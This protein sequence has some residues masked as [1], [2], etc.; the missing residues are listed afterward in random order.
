MAALQGE[1]LINNPGATTGTTPTNIGTEAQDV[2]KAQGVAYEGIAKGAENTATPA[3]ADYNATKVAGDVG[4][5][6]TPKAATSYYDEAQSTVAGRLNS[7]LSSDSAYIKQAEQ[8]AKEEASR[9]GL[10]NSSMAIGAGREAAISQALPIASQDASEFNKFG[11]QQQQTENQQATIQTE[12]IVS[13]EMTKQKAAISQTAQ[14]I[15]NAFNSRLTG[16]NEESKAWLQDLSQSHQTALQELE[17]TQN[18]ALQQFDTT[19]KKA[20]SIRTQA[21]QVMQN[22]QISVE[23]LMTDPDFL[24][25]GTVAVNNAINQMQALAKNTIKFIGASS[26]VDMDAFVNTYLTSLSVR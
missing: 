20:E 25:L 4:V 21:S 7:L 12:A 14:N 23:N 17:H 22:Y 18:L 8:K 15:Q 24:G 9:K 10:L 19:S 16:A 11:L 26:G 1:D 3:Y 13:G 2:A 5:L 6:A